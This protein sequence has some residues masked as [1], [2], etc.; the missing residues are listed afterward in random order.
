MTRDLLNLNLLAKLMVLLCQVL[1]NLS[2]TAKMIQ[3]WISAKQVQSL[4]RVA[5]RYLKLVTFS[6]FWLAV[7][8]SVLMLIMLLVMLLLFSVPTSISYTR[9][10]SVS[11]LVKP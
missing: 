1:F 11:L 4:D 8:K 6:N 10:L 7:L 3:M 9:A 2:I 5:P